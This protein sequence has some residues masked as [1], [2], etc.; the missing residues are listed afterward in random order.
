LRSIA[1]ENGAIARYISKISVVFLIIRFSMAI[2][3]LSDLENVAGK[4]DCVHDEIKRKGQKTD[5]QE[6]A[7]PDSR[8]RIRP[9]SRPRGAPCKPGVVP[10]AGGDGRL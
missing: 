1:D 5:W 4:A 6:C 7:A 3:V 10:N 2:L 8:F 9:E